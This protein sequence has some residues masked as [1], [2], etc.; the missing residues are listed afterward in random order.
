MPRIPSSSVTFA[1]SKRQDRWTTRYS[2]TPTCYANSGDVMLSSKDGS[3]VWKH[4]ASETRN[5]FYGDSFFSEI[6]LTFNDYPSESKVFKALSI[7]TN[8]NLWIGDFKTQNE[9]QGRNR[10]ESSP[11]LSLEDK[12][13]VKYAEIPRS[14]KNSTANVFPFPFVVTENQDVL[15]SAINSVNTSGIFEVDFLVDD[16]ELSAMPSLPVSGGFLFSE[17]LSVKPSGQAIDFNQ[18]I[19]ENYPSFSVI[20]FFP[21][22][23]GRKYVSAVS[24]SE[25]VVTFRASKP[26]VPS[27]S[28]N[29]EEFVNIFV[30]FLSSEKLL[31]KSS[32]EINGDHMRGPYINVHL[33]NISTTPLELHSVNV[34]YELSSSAARLTQN[35]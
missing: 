20:P 12:E 18:F 15:P 31:L 35:S 34:D 24:I 27:E 23:N 21:L 14:I 6:E 5:K 17:I 11:L 4:D 26:F 28:N 22:S 2:F 7:E 1:F 8:Q 16:I 9:H 25:N 3:G 32:A 19:A 30:D 29:F 10:Q 13:G 33:I